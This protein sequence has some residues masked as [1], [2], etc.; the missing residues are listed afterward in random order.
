MRLN[1][2]LSKKYKERERTSSETSHFGAVCGAAG[3]LRLGLPR[4]GR[5]CRE[6]SFSIPRFILAVK[7]MGNRIKLFYCYM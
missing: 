2:L 5:V 6:L 3:Q 7:N 4:V 1:T